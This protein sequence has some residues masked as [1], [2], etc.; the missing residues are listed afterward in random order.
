MIAE[1][2]S[3][4]ASRIE[5]GET[6][7]FSFYYYNQSKNKFVTS[8]LKKVL[9][10]NDKVFLHDTVVT[11]LKE[12]IINAVKAN[13]K[14]Y[15]F[16]SH[17]LDMKD[18]SQ[19]EVGMD[20]FKDYIITEKE[21]IEEKLKHNNLKVEMYFR[22]TPDGTKIYIRNNTPIHP[23][24]MQ[25]IQER[26]QNVKKYENFTDLYD[27]EK[28]DSEGEGLGL[29]LALFFLKNS[30]IGENSLSIASNEK[31][32]QSVVTIPDAL[33]TREFTNE[34]H[35]RILSEL[36]ELP[37]FPDNVHVL[38]ELCSQI[39]A[40]IDDIIERVMLD[41]GLTTAVLRLSNSAGF[42]SRKKVDS[43]GDAVK[44]IG[45][46]NL[47]AIVTASSAKAIMDGRF[48]YYREIWEHCNKVGFYAREIAYLQGRHKFTDKVFLSAMLHDLGKIVLLASSDVLGEWV[49]ELANS[50]E[51]RS[52]TSIEE[53]SVGI[54]HSSIG[55]RISK[56]WNLPDY[57][58]ESIRCHHCPL[59]AKPEY[60]DIVFIVYLANELVNFEKQK[61][62]F[63]HLEI[64]V[65]KLYG[66]AELDAFTEFHNKV[67]D[68]F[69][70]S[71][72]SSLQ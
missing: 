71:S 27:V 5:K 23:I 58:T 3:E 11:V 59:Q 64:D 22:K 26:I 42:I 18:I 44:I 54:S 36:D 61:F 21:N 46:K 6:V 72:G 31:V 57:V 68:R 48:S 28:D 56:K 66:I 51:M 45:M 55:E 62:Q 41:P 40:D 70:E 35:S 10:R 13:S 29:F 69:L 25:R 33:K 7:G 60:Y 4:M 34:I 63:D 14:R 39:D 32:T 38:Q 15:Y 52:S 65:L 1:K 53:V 37:T 2:T 20:S 50:R 47:S 19:Y 17:N 16:I 49:S 24:E 30:G 67:H 8:L 12:L 43:V 9:E